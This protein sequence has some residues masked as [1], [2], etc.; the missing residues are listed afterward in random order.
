MVKWLNPGSLTRPAV[1]SPPPQAADLALALH[2]QVNEPCDAGFG[3]GDLSDL[4]EQRHRLLLEILEDH[5]QVRATVGWTDVTLERL[6]SDAPDVLARYRAGVQGGRFE[7]TWVLDALPF[8][9]LT[10]LDVIRARALT[11]ETI[12]AREAQL[13]ARGVVPL[14]MRLS[15]GWGEALR[16]QDYQY[17]ALDEALLRRAN[18]QFDPAQPISVEGWPVVGFHRELSRVLRLGVDD[19]TL[20]DYIRYLAADYDGK[21]LAAAICLDSEHKLVWLDRF[22]DRIERLDYAF[23]FLSELASAHAQGAADSTAAPSGLEAWTSDEV[24]R[25]RNALFSRA[26]SCWRDVHVLGER[27]RAQD[28]AR[29]ESV[30]RAV[31]NVQCGRRCWELG[32]A[33]VEQALARA[34]SLAQSWLLELGSLPTLPERALGTVRIFEPRDTERRGSLLT[35]QVPLPVGVVPEAVAFLDRDVVVPSQWLGPQ[36]GTAHFLLA[37][38]MDANAFKDLVVLAEYPTTVTEGLD[39]TPHRLCNAW[40]VAL[41]DGHGQVTSIRFQGRELL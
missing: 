41:L 8:P 37:V 13:W 1:P 35:I 20:I 11:W 5:P 15:A 10:S 17:V 3:P 40:L 28:R 7:T 21:T 34:R 36:D 19:D 27:I 4:A 38:D 29:E 31:L 23:V 26:W 2:F 30:Q 16:R 6:A 25:Q 22:L 9:L 39:I 24:S 18:A 32:V 14:A 12:A 33:A